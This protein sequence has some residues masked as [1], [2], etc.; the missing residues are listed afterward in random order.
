MGVWVDVVERWSY[1][2]SCRVAPEEK[3]SAA[4][5]GADYAAGGHRRR[6]LYPGRDIPPGSFGPGELAEILPLV[7]RAL[8]QSR[9]ALLALLGSTDTSNV[10]ALAALVVTIGQNRASRRGTESGRSPDP[11]GPRA[12]ARGTAAAE[13]RVPSLE[14]ERELVE[15]AFR[16]LEERLLEAGLSPEEA[17][18]KTLNMLLEFLAGAPAAADARRFVTALSNIPDRSASRRGGWLRMLLNRLRSWLPRR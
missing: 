6:D 8:A 7:L 13:V 10:L 9:D 5:V 4:A 3:D 15:R 17:E 1:R 16:T 18:Q 2:I 12:G 14:S 11:A